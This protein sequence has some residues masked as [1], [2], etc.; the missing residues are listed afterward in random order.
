MAFIQSPSLTAK[1]KLELINRG[2]EQSVSVA[3]QKEVLRIVAT[4]N[5]MPKL[6]IHSNLRSGLN[7]LHN[8]HDVLSAELMQEITDLIVSA[9]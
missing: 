6:N 7:Y 5:T 8:P 4:G 3:F 2:Y 9:N 1:I